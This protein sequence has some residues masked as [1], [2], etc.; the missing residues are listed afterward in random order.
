VVEPEELRVLDYSPESLSSI[1]LSRLLAIISGQPHVALVRFR[2]EL[3]MG[4]L[5]STYIF[6]AMDVYQSIHK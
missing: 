2:K 4:S 1:S 6:Q 3:V 5:S